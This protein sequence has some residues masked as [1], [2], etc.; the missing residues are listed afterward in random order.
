MAK[1][2][3]FCLPLQWPK[4]IELVPQSPYSPDMTSNDYHLFLNLKELLDG[5]R[6]WSNS[7]LI[8]A[9]NGYFDD[10]NRRLLKNISFFFVRPRSYRTILV[11]LTLF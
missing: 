10:M 4:F 9:V 5:Q 6:F 8:A 7:E 2:K 3:V 1:K 11:L